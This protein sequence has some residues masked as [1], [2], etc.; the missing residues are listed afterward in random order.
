MKGPIPMP[1]T[2]TTVPSH[3]QHE[4]GTVGTLARKAQMGRTTKSI[5][6]TSGIVPASS[7]GWFSPLGLGNIDHFVSTWPSFGSS[8]SRFPKDCADELPSLPQKTLRSS[9]VPSAGRQGDRC[10]VARSSIA[11]D[12]RDRSPRGY[13]QNLP[14]RSVRKRACCR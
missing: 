6:N 1:A 2:A 8:A 11:T 3:E 10:A 5:E 14:R 9:G 4:Y 7:V 13:R 12:C